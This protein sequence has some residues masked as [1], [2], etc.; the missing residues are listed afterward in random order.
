MARL[1][2]ASKGRR[3]DPPSARA[4]H[5]S[6]DNQIIDTGSARRRRGDIFAAGRWKDWAW[7]RARL[8]V[9]RCLSQ[10]AS[11]EAVSPLFQQ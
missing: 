10:I 8:V 2:T 3:P 4:M 6:A 5:P 1:P 7:R 11:R 9:A